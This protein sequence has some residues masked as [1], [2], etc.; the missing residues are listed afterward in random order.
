MAE[1]RRTIDIAPSAILKIIA[2]IVI[3]WLWL[4]LWQLLMILIVAV[5]LAIALDPV[6]RWLEARRV[7]CAIAATMTVLVLTAAVV[8]FFWLAG[9]SLAG[10]AQ[11]LGARLSA[12]ESQT[13]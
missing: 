9:S 6:V 4:Q 10:Q 7:P 8:G 11:Q 5:V 2:A 1:S 3:V 13:L 12:F